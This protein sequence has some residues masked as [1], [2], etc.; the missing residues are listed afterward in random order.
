MAVQDSS[1]S[2]EAV[3]K[4]IEQYESK[5]TQQLGEV[6]RVERLINELLSDIGEPAKYQIIVEGT[7]S[8][9]GHSSVTGVGGGKRKRSRYYGKPLATAV[10]AFL[11]TLDEQPATPI[12]LLAELESGDFDFDGM[13]WQKENRLRSLAMSLAKNT[14]T[15][16][17][18]PSGAFGLNEW[19]PNAKPRKTKAVATEDHTEAAGE[20]PEG[21]DE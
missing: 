3:R 8:A 7:G 14:A 2:V 18:L 10:R 1:S 9:A 15:F 16:H 11:E 20:K 12:E 21:G 17:R 19:Y 6:T 4:V 13:G 5:R